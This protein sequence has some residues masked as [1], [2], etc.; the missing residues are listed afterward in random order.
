M[1]AEISCDECG[2]KTDKLHRRYRGH[3]YCGSC[4][5][6]V[7]V[8][9]QCPSC[10]CTAR[11]PK[12]TPSAVCRKCEAQKPCVRCGHSGKPVGKI[13]AHGTVCASCSPYF[14]EEEPCEVCGR[15]SHRLTRVSRFGDDLRRC[16]RCAIADHGTCKACHRYRNL[17]ASG[18]E[19]LCNLCSSGA[20]KLCKSCGG[21]VPA[22][23][24]VQCENCYWKHLLE[25]R[26]FMSSEMLESEL[27]QEQFLDFSKWLGVNSGFNKAALA[28][29]RHVSFFQEIDRQWR[30]FPAYPDLLRFFGADQ[31]R[32]RVKILEWLQVE[33]NYF[34]DDQLKKEVAEEHRV[35]RMLSKVPDKTKA[36]AVLSQY[37]IFLRCRLHH[38]KITIQT[39]RLS[40]T[41]A[42]ALMKFSGYEFP[43]TRQ[44]SK[45]L[46]SSPG[47]RASLTGF[48]NFLRNH[49]DLKIEIQ[50]RSTSAITRRRHLEKKLLELMYKEWSYID[51]IYWCKF[52]LELFHNLRLSIKIVKSLLGFIKKEISGYIFTYDNNEY[53]LPEPIKCNNLFFDFKVF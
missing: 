1:A 20:E 21:S 39:L 14:R 30:K 45:Y 50:T 22:G 26:A 48:V 13:C 8:K 10:S 31:L 4:Y 37:E 34:I 19:K 40:M 23:R 25:K 42:I 53:F 16:E 32:R 44:V 38:G 6:R 52:S 11:L 9:Q 5:V 2:R 3:G 33:H 15:P 12:N 41:P 7:F 49:Y 28:I 18:G 24:G 36:Q 51:F 47:Q 29:C 43:N 27:L 35:Q 17:D 46:K